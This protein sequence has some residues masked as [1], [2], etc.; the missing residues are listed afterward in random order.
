MSDTYGG[1]V[2]PATDTKFHE[3][4]GIF[5]S[6]SGAVES[7]I[8][9]DIAAAGG[10]TLAAA[11][12]ALGTIVDPLQSLFAAG[13]GWAME[14]VRILR[15]P[16]D[17]L[18]G[19]PKAIEG[20]A[21][22]WKNIERRIYEVTDSF[23]T[24]V[25]DTAAIWAAESAAAYRK[26]AR[27]HAEAIQAMGSIA[28]GLSK[29]TTALGAVVGIARNTIR[30]IIA[31]VVGA[32]I[33]KLVQ[34][35]TAVLIPKALTEVAILVANTSTKIMN[36]VRQLMARIHEIGEGIWKLRHLMAKLSR[37]R[38]DQAR[39]NAD[40]TILMV[41]RVE[42]A[43]TARQGWTGPFKAYGVL[44]QGDASV[45]GP[46]QQTVINTGRAASQANTSQ[47]SGS[48]ADNVRE[49]DPEPIPIDLP[50]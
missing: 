46:L 25:K 13:V 45:Y 9:G 41:H 21:N 27:H 35:A 38:T 6:V 8:K 16:L 50:D 24:E 22:S 47:N 4:A 14:H 7:V 40:I 43:N 36:T 23:V 34:A 3:G 30:D 11:L 44:S 20:H 32:V 29:A 1:L 49:D 37:F 19:D 18:M 28:D 10:N 39:H 17:R 2:A 31:Q 5:E 15:E 42:A 48:A 33:S 26:L 12:A